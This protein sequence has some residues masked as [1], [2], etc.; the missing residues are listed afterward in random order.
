LAILEKIKTEQAQPHQEFKITLSRKTLVFHCSLE[1]LR[2]SLWIRG[3]SFSGAGEQE[4]TKLTR[5]NCGLVAMT[6]PSA[7]FVYAI[8][9]E[10]YL[11]LLDMSR[12]TTSSKHMNSDTALL[13][14]VGLIWQG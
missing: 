5:I 4:T 14:P 13:L 3:L 6:V 9:I 8:A 7:V 11:L 10:N 12:I 2:A 1:F